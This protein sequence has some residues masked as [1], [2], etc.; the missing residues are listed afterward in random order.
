TTIGDRTTSFTFDPRS[1]FLA[2]IK[3]PGTGFE[4]FI[5]NARGAVVRHTTHAGT[6]DYV[7]DARDLIVE[8]IRDPGGLETRT[9]MAY[10]LNGNLIETRHRIEDQ[11]SDADARSLGISKAAPQDR[12]VTTVYDIVNRPVLRRMQAGALHTS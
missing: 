10:D 8:E 7:R 1:G 5:R 4:T 6:V 2:A 9:R 12:V 11:F 3:Y